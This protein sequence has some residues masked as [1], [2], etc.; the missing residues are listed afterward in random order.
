MDSKW[1]FA[2][3]S[4]I[5]CIMGILGAGE[6]SSCWRCPVASGSCRWP[7]TWMDTSS[8]VG[9]VT[10]DRPFLPVVG[11]HHQVTVEVTGAGRRPRISIHSPRP[12]LCCNPAGKGEGGGAGTERQATHHWPRHQN[13]QYLGP[14]CRGRVL[15]WAW[16]PGLQRWVER[17]RF[18]PNPCWLHLQ[19][20][21]DLSSSPERLLGTHS[22][23]AATSG[24][25][26]SL[27][28]EHRERPCAMRVAMTLGSN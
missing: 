16:P 4:A 27:S 9:Q 14:R 10:V 28:H 22:S 23:G 18:P 5:K 13:P 3:G 15:R 17:S 26:Q 25:S 8:Q 21:K 2:G 7:E 11:A 19:R 1:Q 20:Q 24:L 6:P 12:C